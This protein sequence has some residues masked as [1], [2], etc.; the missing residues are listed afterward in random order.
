MKTL[1]LSL[2]ISGLLVGQSFADET[3]KTGDSLPVLSLNDQHDK[4]ATIDP[5]VARI[6]FAADNTA[7]SMMTA[8]L[9][10]KDANWL[11]QTHSVYLADIHKMPSFIAKMFAL[12]KL[13]EKPYTIILGR[14]ESDLAMFP[15][16]KGCVAVTAVNDTKLS[17][18]QFLCTE[19]SLKE[20]LNHQ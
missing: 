9:D 3:L 4:P 6:I 19:D 18:T 17:E 20:A 11:T 16:Q 8:L 13:R 1:L 10:S 7:A 15:R 12:P 14:E 2:M 5:N